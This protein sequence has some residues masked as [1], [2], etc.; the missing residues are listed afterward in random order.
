MNNLQHMMDRLSRIYTPSSAI[1]T[2][3]DTLHL[4]LGPYHISLGPAAYGALQFRNISTALLSNSK[5]SQGDNTTQQQ[6]RRRHDAAL[7]RFRRSVRKLILIKSII[8]QLRLA[9]VLTPYNQYELYTNG[10]YDLVLAGHVH[11]DRSVFEDEKFAEKIK[12]FR[13]MNKWEKDSSLLASNFIKIQTLLHLLTPAPQ[14]NNTDNSSTSK[15]E[16]QTTG[17][18]EKISENP[19]KQYLDPSTIC[20][21]Q[22]SQNI[23]L[24]MFPLQRSFSQQ[25]TQFL[26]PK[27]PIRRHSHYPSRRH[28]SAPSKEK[29]VRSMHIYIYILK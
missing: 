26:S 14:Q 25:T 27:S 4:F 11:N 7:R 5:T 8:D 24:L 3:D 1:D 6:K 23:P 19:T 15:N 17:T 16:T 13:S 21:S 20:C 18:D 29:T 2:R 10:I 12:E 9:S 22:H 28:S